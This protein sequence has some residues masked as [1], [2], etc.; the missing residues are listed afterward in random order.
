MILVCIL[1]LISHKYDRFR[2]QT[3]FEEE[4]H[5]H[6]FVIHLDRHR[7]P[8]RRRRRR[9]KNN[10]IISH[11]KRDV[12]N[13]GNLISDHSTRAVR[14]QSHFC[15]YKRGINNAANGT[16]NTRTTPKFIRLDIKCNID[17]RSIPHANECK[18]EI[19]L[20][21]PMNWSRVI[22]AFI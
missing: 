12:L 13:R 15:E 14:P 21:P 3:N 16:R 18:T 2:R 20:W 4:Q 8:R 7:S 1:P 11:E 6:E 9:A 10:G 22:I 19:E 17:F 5:S